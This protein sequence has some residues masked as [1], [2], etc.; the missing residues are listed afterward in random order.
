MTNRLSSFARKVVELSTRNWVYA[1]R[2]PSS[3]GDVPIFVTPSAGLK[4]LFKPMTKVDPILLRN[5]IEL[6][7]PNDI[8]WDIG[9]NVGLFTFAAAA[10]AGSKGRVIAFEPDTWLVQL[11]RKSAS[12]QP[13]SSA[14]V[15]IVPAAVASSLSLREFTIASRSRASNALSDYGHTQ[16]GKIYEKQTVVA[17]SLDW[18]AERLPMPTLVKCDVEGAEIEVFSGQSRILRD[19]RPVIIVEVGAE[20]AER[21]TDILVLE[22]YCLYDGEK[23]LSSNA[24]ISRAS[25]NTIGIPEEL[26]QQY[27]AD[28]ANGC[29]EASICDTHK[30][31]TRLPHV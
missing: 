19:I 27:I 3:F 14:P 21:M 28:A 13:E 4:Y 11:L 5:A 9:A 10:R 29:K 7:R 17:L 23:P 16:M 2:L 12:A 25:W 15:T 31:G 1:R 26:R 6:I 20:A 8:V 24:E 18:L 22:Q 30:I